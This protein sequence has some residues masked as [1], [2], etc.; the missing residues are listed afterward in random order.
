MFGIRKDVNTYVIRL[1][2]S[3]Q[4]KIQQKR[5]DL[6]RFLLKQRSATSFLYDFAEIAVP[7]YAFITFK[8]TDD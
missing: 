7:L 2:T 6:E 1:I 3:D 8:N 5:A 4:K